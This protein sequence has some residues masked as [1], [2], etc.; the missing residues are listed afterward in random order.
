MPI[1]TAELREQWGKAIRARREELGLSRS[2][3]AT[4]VCVQ[5]E[6]IY[7]IERGQFAG[8]EATRMAIAAALAV[9]VSD[10]YAFPPTEGVA[11]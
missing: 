1:S 2:Q 10:L 8:S 6:T 3:L 11:S 4:K 9:E 5:N 7:R